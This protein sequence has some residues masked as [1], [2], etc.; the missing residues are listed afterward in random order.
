MSLEGQY[1]VTMEEGKGCSEKCPDTELG[2]GP[3]RQRLSRTQTVVKGLILQGAIGEGHLH[4]WWSALFNIVTREKR[5]I[6]SALKHPQFG[7]GVAA[8]HARTVISSNRQSRS[9]GNPRTEKGRHLQLK[10]HGAHEQAV[11][12]A[13]HGKSKGQFR[14]QKLSRI[15]S[16]SPRDSSLCVETS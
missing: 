12:S 6:N 16:R 8:Q 5:L 10:D 14:Q 1:A 3:F 7:E 9:I 15:D 13:L 2:F 11:V 4:V